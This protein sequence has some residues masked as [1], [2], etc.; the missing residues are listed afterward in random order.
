MGPPQIGTLARKPQACCAR[1]HEQI[2]LMARPADWRNRRKTSDHG[3]RTEAI[4]KL[5]GELFDSVYVRPLARFQ[6]LELH[7]E[8]L[9]IICAEGL[10]EVGAQP[11]DRAVERWHMRPLD[12]R[13]SGS[14]LEAR[15]R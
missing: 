1:L 4:A 11:D 7:D 10:P 5:T 6:K 2:N 12:E 3:G 8:S 14:P 15:F 9:G 13:L